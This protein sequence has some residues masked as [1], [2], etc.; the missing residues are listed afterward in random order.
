MS[1]PEIIPLT[2]L[3]KYANNDIFVNVVFRIKSGK[4]ALQMK[5]VGYEEPAVST[6]Y[7]ILKNNECHLAEL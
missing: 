2:Q 7:D 3:Q 4:S 6:T 5:E 1:V